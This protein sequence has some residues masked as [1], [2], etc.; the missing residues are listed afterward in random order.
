MSKK[1]LVADDSV[2]IQKSIGITFA[3]EDF[4]VKFVSNGEDALTTSSAFLPHII[5]AD[6]TM[7]KLGGIELTKKLKTSEQ[8]KNIP[9]LLLAGARDDVDQAKAESLGAVG[10]IQ[11]PFDSNELLQRVNDS[12]SISSPTPAAN[13]SPEVMPENSG[14]FGN[15][16]DLDLGQEEAS[17][18]EEDSLSSG[19]T[20]FSM[21]DGAPLEINPEPTHTPLQTVSP[22]QPQVE[23]SLKT[24]VHYKEE[25]EIELA[26]EDIDFSMDVTPDLEQDEVPAPNLSMEVSEEVEPAPAAAPAQAQAFAEASSSVQLTNE[27]IENIVTRVFQNVIE[28]IAWEVV[29][30]LAERII[31]EE[32]QRLTGENKGTKK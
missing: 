1:I 16:D 12:L 29:P 25:A 11:K 27:Q 13:P 26:N 24:E 6:V 3:Q 2:V 15:M 5:L 18:F 23:D 22:T 9:V 7:P 21:E 4:D 31:R 30:D 19:F 14:A 20:P 17:G 32:I 28:R 10:V 8:T